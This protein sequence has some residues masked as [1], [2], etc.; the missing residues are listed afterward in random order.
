MRIPM[1]RFALAGLV[2]C[3]ALV[4]PLGA[5]ELLPAHRE[6]LE[7]V[8]PIITKAERQ[9]FSQLKKNAER[10]KFIQLFWRQR[11]PYPDTAENEFKKEYMARVR[12]ADQNFGHST[13]K[14]GSQTE[15]GYYY[16]LLG[17]PLE[18][19]FFTTVSQL[20]PL[21]LWFYKGE[22]QY[23]LPA[24]FYLIFY[25]RE[26]LGEYHLY[27][28]GV[29]GPE[30]LI[31]PTLAGRT[32]TRAVA[33]DIIKKVSA[34]LAGASLGYIPGDQTLQSGVLS[35]NT[36]IASIGSLPEKKYSDAY[37]RTYL[38]YKDYV[39]TDYS[40]DYIESSFAG[41]TFEQG[42]RAF[43]HWALEPKKINFSERGGRYQASFELILRLEDDSGNLVLEKE[44]EVPLSITPEQYKAHASQLFAF[45]DILPVIPGRFRL[46]GLL[47][48]K[49]AG[50]FTSFAAT[51]TV[52]EETRGL[53]FGGLI[54]Y[55][56]REKLPESQGR[57]WKAFSFG[58]NHYLVN[59]GNEFPVQGSLGAYVRVLNLKAA[60]LD[61]GK[62]R[63][64]FEVRGS[65]SQSGGLSQTRTL[66]E[67]LAPDGEGLD[68]G[69]FSISSLK[70]GYYSAEIS[71]VGEDNQ[72]L[73][74]ARD[75]L[76][77][78]SQPYPVVPWVYARV[79]EPLPSP[80]L[81]FTLSSEYFLSGRYEK[82][83]E[84]AGQSLGIKDEA[85]TRILLARS[86]Y[87]LGKYRDSLEA[88]IPAYEAT[89]SRE[90]A[91]TIAAD[92]AGLKDWSSALTYLER[93]MAEATETSVLNL[94]AECY[95][96]LNQPDRALPLLQK[97][98]EID[99]NQPS[100]KA[101]EEKAKKSSLQKIG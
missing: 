3:L 55:H 10:D 50:D 78:L 72:K 69:P 53:G 8:S 27:S 91:K 95:L 22:I 41:K 38:S 47:K 28:P 20:W 4:P 45:Q 29:E 101:L 94:A 34:E 81:L 16:L 90:A 83:R 85:R 14:R 31:I 64:V 97:S 25:Q 1:R 99:P 86:L 51:V 66:A 15:R 76:V 100:I 82:A 92:Y 77:V 79:H 80:E 88:A 40:H 93:L 84:L 62:T 57:L 26:G 21:E 46:F 44:E 18:R 23:G 43:F 7:D 48:N 87:G 2:W 89:K 17:P 13:S 74:S 11:D 63:V 58:G 61:P 70:P 49:T 96:N 59:T 98:L 68:I 39:E 60:N 73:V 33:Y 75:N 54:L 71:L 5:D 6:W 52:P 65:D 9:V 12:F 30:K 37:A 36:V 19:S 32:I 24:Y 56:G 67:A 35:S 42:G